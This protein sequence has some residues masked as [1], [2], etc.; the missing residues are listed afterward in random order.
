MQDK[1]KDNSKTNFQSVASWLILS[2]LAVTLY[3]NPNSRDPFNSPKLWVLM[4]ASAWISGFLVF[5]IKSAVMDKAIN[6]PIFVIIFFIL[7]YTIS[8][9]LS[10]IKFTAFFGENQRRDG[11]LTY[12]ALAIIMLTTIIYFRAVSFNKLLNSSLFIAAILSIYGYMQLTGKDFVKWNNPY[13]SIISTLGNPNFAAAAM[14]IFSIILFGVLFMSDKPY[15]Y[16]IF[17]FGLLLFSLYVIINSEARQGLLAFLIGATIILASYIYNRNKKVGAIFTGISGIVGFF[18]ILG[19]LQIGPLT[20]YLYKSSVTV[21][22]YYWRA[23]LQMFFEQPFFGVGVDRYGAYFK[24][25]R[26]P[27]YPLKYGFNITSSNAHNVFVQQFATAG[28]FVGMSYLILTIMIFRIGI[29][30]IFASDNKTRILNTTI[31]A[32][33]IAYQAQSLISID[34]LGV[35]YWG[36]FLGGVLIAMSRQD[37][38]IGNKNVPGN[39][40]IQS[41]AIRRVFISSML[42]IPVLI[43]CVFLY[44]N[45]INMQSQ[46]K[47]YNPSESSNKTIFFEAADK[48]L[49]TK[50]LEP[51]YRIDTGAYLSAM[52]YPELGL[53]ILRK[54][55]ESDPRNLDNL[56]ILAA[57][58]EQ[59]NESNE[60][61]MYRE[62]ISNLDPWNADNYLKLG[63]AYKNLGNLNKMQEMLKKIE[64]FASATNEAKLARINLVSN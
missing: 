37:F 1:T 4:L 21:R 50:I 57:F 53:E 33:W 48:T 8:T 62:A 15:L 43:I 39:K 16:R 13:N 9:L 47:W 49:K 59:L 56:Q 42:T 34:S 14:A 51:Y 29:K 35:A 61:I 18:A 19:M 60:T 20:E 23:G 25:F 3:F 44:R 46:M 30:N 36:W 12:L 58:S 52:G 10:P 54:S 5:K 24:E 41:I 7:S 11:F 63:I 26:E 22:G 31:F 2:G 55:L 45:E 32:A 40:Q 6:K 64:S 27:S 38:L 17:S 28:F